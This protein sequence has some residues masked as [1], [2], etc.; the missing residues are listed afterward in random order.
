MV[1]TILLFTGSKVNPSEKFSN[2]T[3]ER[4]AP[5]M[6]FASTNTLAIPPTT[7]PVIPSPI[8]TPT[9]TFSPSPSPSAL[10]EIFSSPAIQA[11]FI[12][13]MDV[14]LN[15][16]NAEWHV[17]L[18]TVEGKFIYE[19]G[20]DQLI[21]PAS[22]IKFPIA[23]LFLKWYDQQEIADYDA[24]LDS[25]GTGGRTFNQLLYAMIVKTEEQASEI[26]V[27]WVSGKLDT[28]KT[29]ANWGA[30]NTSLSPRQTTAREMTRLYTQ[31]VSGKLISQRGTRL[32]TR[33]MEEYTPNDDTRLGIL[34]QF[35]PPGY[36]FYNKRGSL[37]DSRLIVAD[38]AVIELP[39]N[40]GKSTFIFQMYGF[41]GKSPPAVTYEELDETIA[42]AA[43]L[44]WR[45]L[46]E[47]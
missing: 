33:L 47:K 1:F 15:K 9:Q 8:P 22:I 37:A 41:P 35:Q 40:R 10:P 4:A 25:R 44:F 23:L 30:P 38:A 19:R 7:P 13:D 46:Q 5:A 24:Y 39:T 43:R 3:E 34:R 45:Y 16:E 12:R 31:F 29:L 18:Q 21:H 28:R 36:R 42:R 6:S 14:L 20:P 27:E 2:A 32:L 17:M 26:L 11:S